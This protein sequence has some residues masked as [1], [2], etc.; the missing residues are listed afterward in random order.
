MFDIKDYYI[1]HELSNNIFSVLVITFV[2]FM[3]F[4]FLAKFQFHFCSVKFIA[5]LFKMSS[6]ISFLLGG[7]IDLPNC[8]QLI[9]VEVLA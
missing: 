2:C 7:C 1:Y 6:F 3:L 8:R 5:S 9:L 4:L